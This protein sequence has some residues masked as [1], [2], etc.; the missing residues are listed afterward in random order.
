MSEGAMNDTEK[1]LIE[2]YN[3]LR[4]LEI[5]AAWAYAAAN[6]QRLVE[7]VNSFEKAYECLIELH[8]CGKLGA[9]AADFSSGNLDRVRHITRLIQSGLDSSET[10]REAEE[11]HM[12]AKECIQAL[13]RNEVSIDEQAKGRV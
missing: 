1:L 4:S 13:T 10:R 3:G 11:I 12:L 6:P 5:L 9:G 8:K 7:Q 2:F